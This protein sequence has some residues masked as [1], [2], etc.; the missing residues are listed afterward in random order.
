MDSSKDNEQFG[1]LLIGGPKKDSAA[2]V[3][4][5]EAT[6]TGHE[7]DD[8][9][10]GDINMPPPNAQYAWRHWPM[11]AGVVLAALVGAI[12]GAG[13]TATLRDSNPPATFADATTIHTLQTSVAQLSSELA[14]VKSGVASAQRSSSAQFGKLT[15]RLDRSEKAQEKAQAEPAAKLAKIQES[16]DRLEK[17]PQQIAAAPVVAAPEVTG[18]ITPKES[19]EA[20][21]EPKPVVAQGWAL[22]DYY[23]GR[24]IVENR[25]G[26]LF[27]VGAGGTLPGLGKVA[28]IKRDNGRITVVTTGGIITA[29]LEQPQPPRR[30]PPQYYRW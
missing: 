17:R 15:E 30:M 7:H 5:L 21:E 20:T 4:E 24:A 27:R 19:K 22:V 28:S 23:D 8:D 26:T 14:T 25:H 6:D 13:T 29:A 9:D 3:I 16:I 2:P 18:S 1:P 12:A 10:I 11:A